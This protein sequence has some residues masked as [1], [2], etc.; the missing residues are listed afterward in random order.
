MAED[1]V[2]AQKG[3]FQV[4]LVEGKA[5]FYCRC[6][7]SKTQPFCDGSHKGTGLE[8][9]KFEAPK[10]G[11]FNLCGCKTTDDEPYCDGSHNML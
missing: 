1:P 5:Y 2:V 9:M 11:T 10:T 7:R 8:P 6:G 3:P 4:D